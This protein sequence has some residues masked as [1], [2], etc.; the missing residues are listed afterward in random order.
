[1]SMT[2]PSPRGSR[3]DG[4]GLRRHVE[5]VELERKPPYPTIVASYEVETDEQGNVLA[6]QRFRR[7]RRGGLG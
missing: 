4:G 1:M 3:A 6:L 7:H 2:T 5:I